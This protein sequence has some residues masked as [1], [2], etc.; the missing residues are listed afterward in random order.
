MAKQLQTTTISAPGFLGI[1][2][3]ESSVD[4]SSGYAL[5]AYNCVIDK[6]GRIGARK[7]W[8]KQNSSTNSDLGTNDI[9]FLFELGET[10]QVIAGGNNLLL[11]LDSGVLTTAVDTTVSNAAGTGTTAYTITGNNWSASSIVFGEGPDISPHAYLAQTGHLPLVY[12]KLGASHAH[13]GVYGFN[14]LSDAGSVPTTYVSSPSDFKPNVVLGA[15]GRTWW[16]NV[17]NDE[18]TVYFSALLDGTNLSTGDSGYLSLVDV[19]PN[20]DQVVGLAAHNGFLVIFGKRNIAIYSNPIDVTR[21]ELVDLIANVGCIARDTIINTGTDVMFLSDTGLRSISRVI[22]E[23]SAPINNISFNVRDD[24]VAFVDSETNKDRIKSAYYPKD[25]FY[26]LTLPTSKY[27]FC[28]DLRGRLQNGAC[29]VTIWDSI[30]PTAFYTT[31]AG[32]LLIGKEGY[33]GKYISYL[34]N[35]TIYKMRYYTNNFDLGNPTSLKVLKKANFTVVGGVGQNVFIKYGFD[36]ISSYRDIRKTLSAGSVYEFNVNK[37]GVNNVT[38]VG[39]QSFSNSTPTTNTIT[40]TD[41]THYQVAFKSVFDPSNGYDLPQST[42]FDSG[43]GFYYVPDTNSG[44]EPNAI[45]Y[46]KSADALSEYSSGLAL[47]E[48]RSNLGGSG[49]ILQLGFEADINQNPL[50]IQKIDVYVKTGKII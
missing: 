24:L 34:D 26:V 15:Y 12:H 22:Q 28:F 50:S 8:T 39:S 27:V 46:L 25:A 44:E 42:K 2:T 14:L 23:K 3:Q 6:F 36:Y 11:T 48:V 43:D 7:G 1:N 45:I 33:V 38:V 16:A 30:E 41:G 21:L 29:R 32:D 17:V 31:Y 5:E 9:E 49:S 13:T 35:D 37:F 4:L 10:E 20:G 47:E 40:D 19:F 18:Q